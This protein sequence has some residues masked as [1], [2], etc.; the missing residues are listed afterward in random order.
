MTGAGTAPA[1]ELIN[2]TKRYGEAVALDRVSLQIESGEFFCLLGPSGCGKTTTLNLIGG[3]IP[4]TSG[5][6]RIEGQ[7][8]NDLPPHQ[9]DVNTVFQNYALFPHMSVADNVAFGLRMESLPDDEIGRRVGE[10]L[11]LVGLSEYRD[12][13]PGQ[14]SGGQAQRVALARALAKRPTVL[15]LDEPLGALDLKLRKQMQVELARIHR[16]VGTTFV[17][18]THD[19]E[20]ALSMATR[21]AVMAG[22]H[23]RQIGTPREIYLGPVDRFVADF[24]GE[25]NF[26]DGRVASNGQGPAFQLSNGTV[27]PIPT[28]PD[29]TQNG[30]VALMIR[31]ESVGVGR[32]APGGMTPNVVIDGRATNVAFMGNHTRITVQTDAGI[33]VA[34]RFHGESDEQA[35]EEEMLDQEVHV[36][37]DPRESTVV[38]ADDLRGS[39]EELRG[40]PE[41]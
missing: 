40:G 15:L 38:T 41:G 11:E 6:L 39:E 32:G 16:Q 14:L 30:R 9:R 35:V 24:I 10:Y 1:I 13:Y 4:L 7:R 3:F 26:L 8:V 29:G 37:W 25:S 18:V 27:V 2:V 36:W 23:V 20:E 31:P 22:G 33:L 21:I 12:R 28:E 17:F 5:E 34:L 19:Q